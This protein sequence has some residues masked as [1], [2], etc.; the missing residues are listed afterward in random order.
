ML[1]Y[2]LAFPLGWGGIGIWLGFVFGLLAASFL[3][4]G[5]FAILVRR[6][7]KAA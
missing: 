1:A 7:E 6:M 4:L 3:L 2:V 5:R